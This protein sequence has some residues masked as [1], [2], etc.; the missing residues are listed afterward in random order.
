MAPFSSSARASIA[1]ITDN[2]IPAN[3]P[4]ER[5]NQVTASKTNEMPTSS[6]GNMDAVLQESV[7]KGEAIR[8]S[9]APNRKEVWSRSQQKRENAMVGPRFEQMIMEDQVC[10][11][12]WVVSPSS[13]NWSRN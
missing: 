6:E 7:E 9:Q 12:V 5:G 1:R 10:A 11:A 4:V 2:P 13:C 8:T 3:D